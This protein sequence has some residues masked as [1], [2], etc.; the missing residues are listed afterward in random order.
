MI[1]LTLAAGFLLGALAYRI[2]G[3]LFD[4][5]HPWGRLLFAVPLSVVLVLPLFSMGWLTLCAMLVVT[6]IAVYWITIL[7]HGTYMDLGRNPEGHL[8]EP[9][10][11]ISWLIG[12]EKPE[13]DAR[14]RF[15]HNFCGLLLKGAMLGTFVAVPLAIVARD[16]SY[17]AFMVAAASMPLC[18]LAAW[19]I[20]SRIKNFE[21]GPA[22][23]EALYGGVLG[24]AAT[25]PV[26]S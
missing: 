16:P 20:P 10:R 19:N 6:L 26:I 25:L 24:A 17:I 7:G 15:C 12:D 11:P 22:L 2:R 14:Q 21:Q 1:W 5:G 9:E 23:G 13:W 8:D 3:G 18:Y 4:L